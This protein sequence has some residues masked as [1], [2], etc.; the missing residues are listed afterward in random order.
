MSELSGSNGWLWLIPFAAFSAA[1][2]GAACGGDDG[3]PY[4]ELLFDPEALDVE[5]EEVL[6]CRFSADHD[7]RNLRVMADEVSAEIYERCVLSGDTEG[8]E[9]DAFPAGSL[10]VALEYDDVEC[11][12]DRF[13]GYAA[14]ERLE[15]GAAPAA[16]DWEWQ[17]VSPDLEPEE[18]GVPGDCV[19]CHVDH[20]ATPLGFDLRCIPN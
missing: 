15:E 2:A 5:L 3:D 17:R 7:Q 18:E 8:C 16:F 19:Q 1:A 6:D 13:E 20:C 10:F 11:D 9:E 14:A 4:D 12:E